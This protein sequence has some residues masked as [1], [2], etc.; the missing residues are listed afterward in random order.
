MALIEV[1]AN[2]ILFHLD[3]NETV[4]VVCR[5]LQQKA[6]DRPAVNHDILLYKL[7]DYGIRGIAH[8]WFRSYLNSRPTGSNT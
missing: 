2:N 7:N 3:N 5:D 4:I 1:I 8:E 6:F